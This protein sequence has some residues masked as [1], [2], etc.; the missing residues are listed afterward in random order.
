MARLHGRELDAGINALFASAVLSI[1]RNM[2][3]ATPADLRQLIGD[4]HLDGLCAE[5][6]AAL[7]HEARVVLGETGG[8]L[9]H[10]A[11][12]VRRLAVSM[13]GG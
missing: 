13:R 1:H 6:I 10:A 12:T 2:Q 11:D 3:I 8:N 9:A 5:Q 7:M 4:A